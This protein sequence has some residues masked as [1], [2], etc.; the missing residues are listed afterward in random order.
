[1]NAPRASST[2]D[3]PIWKSLLG[4]VLKLSVTGSSNSENWEMDEEIG[5]IHFASFHG[6][7]S[8]PAAPAGTRTHSTTQLPA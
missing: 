1:M 3:F 5:L 2:K 6:G 7:T 8:R 4:E